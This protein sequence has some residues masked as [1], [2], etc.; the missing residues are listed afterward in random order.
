MGEHDEV[1]VPILR[2]EGKEIGPGLMPGRV[3]GRDCGNRFGA[4]RSV[5]KRSP[6]RVLGE[7]RAAC[8]RQC[9]ERSAIALLKPDLRMACWH[10]DPTA[11]GLT[12]ND[13]KDAR[14]LV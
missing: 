12:V 5:G 9:A 10:N 3:A 8:Y 4:G 13:A 1:A 14:G 6:D 7:R 2:H 11:H